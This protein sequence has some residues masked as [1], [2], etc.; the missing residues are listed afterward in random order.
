[1]ELISKQSLKE[2]ICSDKNK[3]GFY[4]KEKTWNN[5]F[6]ENYIELLSWNFPNEFTFQQKI[7]HYLND[8]PELMLGICAKCG[9]RC[10]F[11]TIPI[12][13]ATY[14]SRKCIQNSQTV[15]EKA[16][17][18]C[19]KNNGV[20][21]PGQAE[22]VKKKSQQ[23]C[24]ERYGC[25]YALQ[26]EEV[27]EKAKLTKLEKYDDPNYHNIVKAI[28][29]C[30]ERYSCE[31]PFQSEEIKE[32][33]KETC[34]RKYGV[35][36]WLQT[37]E[38]KNMAKNKSFEKYNCEYFSQSNEIKKKKE[39]TNLTHI[40]VKYP[41]QS[42]LVREKQK[43]T[44]LEKYGKEY[45][46]QTDEFKEK[47]N[48]AKFVEQL[49]LANQEKYGADW[50]F[51]SEEFKKKFENYEWVKSIN[52][53]RYNTK[54]QN[55]SFN[56]SKIEEQIKLYL[57]NNNISYIYQY[58]SDLYPFSCDFYFPDKDLYVEIQGSWTHG[59]QPFTNSD[60]DLKLLEK[61]KSKN[62]RYYDNA[63][64]TWTIRDVKKRETAKQNNLNY[65]EIFSIDL[66]ECINEINKIIYG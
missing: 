49:K 55:N 25:K 58:T 28:Q 16:I 9:N 41:A 5:I 21:Y 24:L 56:T 19:L 1:M 43:Q 33:I 37:E 59:S 45:Y 60:E 34:L 11:H 26:S 40:G 61:W 14:C 23:T 35:E 66:D 65:L 10:R 8:D 42:E 7:Y 17:Q 52:E 20:K 64:K 6:K 47:F 44:C 51:T 50:Y 31:N 54:K 38:C 12:G 29:T 15:R 57:D 4:S 48:D 30:L 2:L 62:T 39:E 18:T 53:K 63:V 36:Y 27:R 46:S 32:K 22:I 13:Y 3:S